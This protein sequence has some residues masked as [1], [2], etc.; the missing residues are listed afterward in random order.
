[1]PSQEYR[2]TRTLIVPESIP[3]GEYQIELGL[4][5]PTGRG[6]NVELAGKRL[7]ARSVEVGRLHI[8]PPATEN[9]VKYVSGWYGPEHDP[10]NIWFHWRWTKKTAVLQVRNPH[11][12]SVLY[13][14]IDSDP[15]RFPTPQ[16]LTVKVND[17]VIDHFPLQPD[18]SDLR[19][20]PISGEVLG[21]ADWVDV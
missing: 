13:L 5:A 21:A 12:D 17:S 1:V 16:Q 18:T 6:E 9:E 14:K 7:T 8:L 11:A 15:N 20:Y 3:A 4:Y 19:K 10:G 2:Y